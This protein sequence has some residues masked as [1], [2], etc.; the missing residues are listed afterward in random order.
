MAQR[1]IWTSYT[2]PCLLENLTQAGIV[3]GAMFF[4]RLNKGKLIHT[5]PLERYYQTSSIRVTNTAFREKHYACFGVSSISTASSLLA[6]HISKWELRPMYQFLQFLHDDPSLEQKKMKKQR[7]FPCQLML[8]WG[9][10][11]CLPLVSIVS[12]EVGA[13]FAGPVE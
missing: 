4:A 11:P 6:I 9:P 5:M 1:C 10:C 8:Q 7:P 13:G 3:I 2:E 12:V